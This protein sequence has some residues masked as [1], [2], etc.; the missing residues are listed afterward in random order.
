MIT[1]VLLFANSLMQ[2][3][4]QPTLAAIVFAAALSLTDVGGTRRL[5]RQRP[6]EFV[7]SLVAFLGVAFLGVLPGIL[8]AVGLSILNVFRRTWWPHQAEL[9]LLPVA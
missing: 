8:L 1:L 2:Y 3:V 7:L 9:G 6:A 5:L 4:P